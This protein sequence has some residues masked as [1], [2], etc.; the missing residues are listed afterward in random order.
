MKSGCDERSNRKLSGDGD[1]MGR[2]V[3]LTVG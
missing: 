1:A 3:E 2:D